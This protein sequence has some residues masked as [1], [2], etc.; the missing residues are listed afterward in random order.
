MQAARSHGAVF[1]HL[2][3][4]QAERD[5]WDS[6]SDELVANSLFFVLQLSHI[7]L[8][9]PVIEVGSWADE[10]LRRVSSSIIDGLEPL[11]PPGFPPRGHR[12]SPSGLSTYSMASPNGSPASG[13]V[14]K[15]LDL[16]RRRL[17]RA[18]ETLDEQ[19]I[20]LYTW[21]RGEDVIQE[22]VGI[23][24]FSLAEMGL[25]DGRG[26]GELSKLV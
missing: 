19:G 13:P 16:W 25:K 24:N 18:Q 26:K 11:P 14:N 21:R 22:A 20:A 12:R 2:L 1:S 5:G 23:V 10:C 15:K 9:R 8:S 17:Q 4:T 6:L 3:R 7:T